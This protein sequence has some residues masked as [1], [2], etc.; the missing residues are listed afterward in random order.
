MSVISVSLS[1]LLFAMVFYDAIC[2]IFT[3]MGLPLKAGADVYRLRNL[4]KEKLFLVGW[5][6]KSSKQTV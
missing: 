5:F 3:I 4:L 2:L 6:R 1:T